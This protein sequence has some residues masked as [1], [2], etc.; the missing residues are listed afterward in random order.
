MPPLTYHANS[1]RSAIKIEYFCFISF[2]KKVLLL[3][4]PRKIKNSKIDNVNSLHDQYDHAEHESGHKND[5][6]CPKGV[7]P[8]P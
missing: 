7:P 1:Y 3:K 8:R 6:A 4:N 5:V 2:P